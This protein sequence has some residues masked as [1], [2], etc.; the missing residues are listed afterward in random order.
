MGNC[1][2]SFDSTAPFF[3]LE[4]LIT[5]AK[6]VDVYD[7]DTITCVFNTFG[8]YYRWKVRISHIDTPEIKTT[9]LI[10]K[11]AGLIVKR[12]VSTLILGNVVTLKCGK[13]EKYGRL[14]GDIEYNGTDVGKM[15]LEN[16]YA[17][18]YEGKTKPT[19]TDQELCRISQT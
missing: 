8:K 5:K 14:L 19:W 10:E 12:Y 11:Q 9:N 15:L 2:N 1:C 13:F 17:H 18:K 16:G 3:S 7:G 6:V 4:G